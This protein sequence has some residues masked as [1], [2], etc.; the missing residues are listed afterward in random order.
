MNNFDRIKHNVIRGIFIRRGSRVKRSKRP[1]EPPMV[2]EK[3]S[4]RVIFIRISWTVSVPLGMI[5][6]GV[7]S[8][9]LKQLMNL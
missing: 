7:L 1:T 4:I 6:S 5:F 2:V 3:H 9:A 8:D